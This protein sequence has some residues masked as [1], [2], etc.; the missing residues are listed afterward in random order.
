M[1]AELATHNVDAERQ[2]CGAVLLSEPALERTRSIDLQ[3][4][5]FYFKKHG[6]LYAAAL[7]L[8]AAGKPVDE[9]TV[10]AELDRAGDLA[11]VGG[12]NAVSELAATVAAPGNVQHHAQIVKDA[13]QRRATVEFTEQALNAARSGA[14]PSEVSAL[15]DRHRVRERILKPAARKANEILEGTEIDPIVKITLHGL[16]RTCAT[17]RIAAGDDPVYVSDQLGHTDPAFTMRIYARA[18]KRRRKLSGETL[19]AFDQALQLA[20]IGRIAEPADLDPFGLEAAD[21]AD[22]ALAKEMRERARQDSN[23]RPHAP[24]ACALSS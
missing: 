6:L 4:E 16:R 17:L 24:E 23:L 2:V 11:A 9:I 10:K 1:S 12:Q 14:D 22:S 3:L 19:K 18:T 8:D 13:A 21:S 15:L 7:A 5:D 20:E